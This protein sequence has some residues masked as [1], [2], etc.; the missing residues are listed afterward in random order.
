MPS[1]AIPRIQEHDDKTFA[2]RIEE[3]MIRHVQPPVSGGLIRS[4][5]MLHRFRCGTFLDS[6]NF[7][8]L[9]LLGSLKRYFLEQ[10]QLL[11]ILPIGRPPAVNRLLL[12]LPFFHLGAW[13]A[14]LFSG[15]K[16]ILVILGQKDGGCGTIRFG[17]DPE[18]DFVFTPVSGEQTKAFL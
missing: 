1:N 16:K 5:A 6:H 15:W 10:L 14:A 9:R 4:I 2:L 18:F 8:L 7:P 17:D 3:R 13:T 11:H 12:G